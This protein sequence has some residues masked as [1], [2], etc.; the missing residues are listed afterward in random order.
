MMLEIK[1]V[2]NGDKIY[3]GNFTLWER[4]TIIKESI[5]KIL[6]LFSGK[7]NIG[8][9]RVDYSF[10]NI[11]MSVFKY[12]KEL[13]KNKYK[14]NTVIIDAPYNEKT[15]E[16]YRKIGNT[17]K[18]FIIFADVKKTTKLF[19]LI[20]DKVLP[21]IIIIKSWNYYIPKGYKLKKGYVCYPGGYRKSTFLLILEMIKREKKMF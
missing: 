8:D 21:K 11:K 14:F 15:A 10:G 6:H 17:P 20:D 19:K 1:K 7:S 5:G 9:I 4:K 18:Q 13:D 16:R 12:L 2:G 3:P